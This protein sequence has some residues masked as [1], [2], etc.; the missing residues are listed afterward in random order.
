MWNLNI[1]VSHLLAP[2]ALGIAGRHLTGHYN[3]TTHTATC[4]F[5]KTH[6]TKNFSYLSLQT[7]YS[8]QVTVGFYRRELDYT[9]IYKMNA[10]KKKTES[11]KSCFGPAQLCETGGVV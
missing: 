3:N 1:S 2:I 6:T 9:D 11:Q 5:P 7:H 8:V 10:V 4:S